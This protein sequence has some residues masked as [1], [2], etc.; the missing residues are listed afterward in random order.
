[1]VTPHINAQKGDFSERV[2]MSGDP[3]RVKY[4]ADNFLENAYEVTNVRSMLGFTGHYK[5]VM[6]SVMSHGI[7]IPSALIYIKELIQY[8]N[9]KKIIRVGTCGAVRNDI[10]LKDI[11]IAMGA[12]TDSKVNRLKFN[13]YDFSAIA[14]FEMLC[15]AVKYSKKININVRV[16]NFFT[17]DLFYAYDYKIYDLLSK[18]NII[19]IDMETSGIYSISSELNIQT[20]SICSVSDHIIHGQMLSVNDRENSFNDMI[21]IALETI[22]I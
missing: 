17:T 19:G 15:N 13:N 6:V 20:V 21:E 5:N 3:I 14:D 12:C 4:I 16:G 8:Y 11:V 9:I 22:I 18:Y 7:G 10:K 1:M 2:I